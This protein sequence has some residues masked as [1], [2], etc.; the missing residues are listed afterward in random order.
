[1]DLT[2]VPTDIPYLSVAMWNSLALWTVVTSFQ[3][4]RRRKRWHH[5]HLLLCPWWKF[6]RHAM[7]T[8]LILLKF[9]HASSRR[10]WIAFP[11]LTSSSSTTQYCWILNL[12]LLPILW[13]KSS[14]P[15]A[16]APVRLKNW[17]MKVTLIL[18]MSWAFCSC[19]TEQ[20]FHLYSLNHSLAVGVACGGGVVPPI[21]SLNGEPQ[22]SSVTNI[23]FSQFSNFFPFF[24]ISIEGQHLHDLS[25]KIFMI[26]IPFHRT[27]MPFLI[28][29]DPQSIFLYEL[30]LVNPF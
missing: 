11:R 12:P 27:V 4:W 17:A 23:F 9:C 19:R 28:F 18:A 10:V 8:A 5:C 1:M 24:Y 30:I 29:L 20:F 13:T 16:S 21:L 26:L 3:R 25:D 2:V 22:G 14:A 6:C 15:S 7:I